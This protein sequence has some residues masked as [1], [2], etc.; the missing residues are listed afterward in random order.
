MTDFHKKFELFREEFSKERGLIMATNSVNSK[1]NSDLKKLYLEYLNSLYLSNRLH[2]AAFA[3]TDFSINSLKFI[4]QGIK[5]MSVSQSLKAFVKPNHKD[6]F[7]YLVFWLQSNPEIFAQVAYLYLVS[8][9]VLDEDK[10][11]FIFNT[12]PVM[13]SNYKTYDEQARKTCNPSC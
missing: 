8:T 6:R 13:Y 4:L 3:D 7:A 2:Y 12:F 1:A 11:F 10:E 5:P 9:D